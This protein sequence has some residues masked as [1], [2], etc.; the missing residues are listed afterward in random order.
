MIEKAKLI[1]ITGGA[2]SGKSEFA[3]RLAQT[4]AG[5]NLSAPYLAYIATAQILDDEMADRVK[6]HQAR[7]SEI[8]LT[9]EAPYEAHLAIAEAAQE[10]DVILFDCLTLYLTNL[11]LAA[12]ESACDEEQL[13]HIFDQ[14]D[15]LLAACREGNKT[16]ILVTNEVG[17]GIVPENALARK[18]RDW[19]GWVNQKVAQ[20][21]DEVYFVVS[22][23]PVEIKSLGRKLN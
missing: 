10:V 1:L 16:V 8:W 11:L 19:A 4:L 22:G 15:K 6:H 20:A 13:M 17:M 21:A 2:R 5:Q 14:I 3:E 7:R 18:Y 23:I 12:D 9:K